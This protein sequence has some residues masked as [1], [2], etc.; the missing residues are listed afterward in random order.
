M[1]ALFLTLNGENLYMDDKR[2]IRTARRRFPWYTAWIIGLIADV[3]AALVL[4]II[5]W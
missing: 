5:R 3:I 4:L 1:K 2:R